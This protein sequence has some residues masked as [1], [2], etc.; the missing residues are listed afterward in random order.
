MS[1]TTLVYLF[2]HGEVVR[3]ETRRFIGHLDVPLSVR[4]EAQCLAQRTHLRDVPLAALYSSDLARARRSGELLGS[5]GRLT[6]VIVPA[7]REMGMGRWEGLTAEEIQ[8]R[9]PEAFATWMSSVGEF[10]FPEGESV[11]DLVAR[12]WP[13]FES[14]VDAHAGAA[15]GVVAH[16]GTN[17]AVLCRALG[18]PL[19]RLLAFGQGYGALTVLR[20]AGG[21]WSLR[22]LN[23]EPV[24]IG[25]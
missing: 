15:I 18:L 21:L 10:P 12:A 5:I 14:I 6:P 16:G 1:S 17:R 3:A 20:R 22:R 7:L 24:M 19:D 11:P 2:R 13:A 4:G 9:E 25:P 8:A 23:E